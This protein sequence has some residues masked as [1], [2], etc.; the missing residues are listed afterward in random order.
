MEY[1][2]LK[3]E[4]KGL[5]WAKALPQYQKILNEDPKEVLRYKS[6]FEIYFARKPCNNHNRDLESQDIISDELAAT[7]ANCKLA[8]KDRKH[9][10]RYAKDVR[11]VAYAA[12]ERCHRRMVNAHLKSNPPSRYRIG[13]KV[14]V[15]LAKKGISKSS[16][17]QQ[18][19]E[20]LVEKRNLKQY[21]YKVSF[22]SPSSG[23]RER[24]WFSVVD[25]TSLTLREEKL[26]QKAA[27]IDKQKRT[28]HRE[29]LLILM[30]SDDYLKIIEDQGYELVHNPPGNGNCQFAALAYQ[31]RLLGISRSAETL[32]K[33]IL[34]YLKTHPLDE[35]G[36]PLYEWV[37]HFQSWP[38]YLVHMAQ[39]HTFGD[40]LTL[41]AAANLFNVNIQIV[42]SLGAGASHVF[43]PTSSI[44]I[45]T[46]FLGHFA[47]NHGEHYIALN[48]LSDE[49][50]H[51]MPAES[52]NY[53][54]RENHNEIDDNE[55]HDDDE[56]AENAIAENSSRRDM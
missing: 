7:N 34:R 24:R 55:E 41:F 22:I 40:Q 43:Q 30:E 48:S 26:K 27:K 50:N 6:P 18:V 14:H 2:L 36:F 46:L 21:S 53:A 13:E 4:K 29:K 56:I 3:M 20:G 10:F 49:D 5:N 15:R 32:R 47:E 42:S 54:Q 44:P 9:R 16:R 25:I 17:K 28:I 39:D 31:L 1:D 8:D 35:D 12:T 37:P 38:D 11:K 52:V 51:E 19:V 45:A 23:R 33:K